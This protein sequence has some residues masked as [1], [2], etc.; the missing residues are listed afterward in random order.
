M[1][2]N[3]NTL[4]SNIKGISKNTYQSIQEHCWEILKKNLKWLKIK[5]L[6]LSRY[7]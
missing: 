7:F 5:A 2:V 4:P 6:E 1:S 3:T